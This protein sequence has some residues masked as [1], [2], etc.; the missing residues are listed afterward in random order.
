[1]KK[2]YEMFL[3]MANHEI[4]EW[5]KFIKTLKKEYEKRKKITTK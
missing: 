3:K 1:M 4:K 2:E 5:E